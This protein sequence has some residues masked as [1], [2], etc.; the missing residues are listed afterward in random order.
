MRHH[1]K[2]PLKGFINALQQPPRDD[3]RSQRDECVVGNVSGVGSDNKLSVFLFSRQTKKDKCAAKGW[4]VVGDSER[5]RER[6][7]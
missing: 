4:G 2:R 1:D 6:G 3:T 7:I 5:E